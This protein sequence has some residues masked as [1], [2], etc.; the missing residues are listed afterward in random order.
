MADL[1]DAPD[2]GH[3]DAWEGDEPPPEEPDQSP[4][5]SSKKRPSLQERTGLRFDPLPV[6]PPRHGFSPVVADVREKLREYRGDLDC[7]MWSMMIGLGHLDLSGAAAVADEMDR[8]L[9]RQT[10]RA[11]A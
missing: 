7:L 4:P 2:D 1:F 5:K 10:G 8:Q 3:G 11:A 9:S 6:L